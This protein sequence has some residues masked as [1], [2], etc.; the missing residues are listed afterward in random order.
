MMDVCCVMIFFAGIGLKWLMCLYVR[1]LH[2]CCA[3]LR[4]V[5]QYCFMGAKFDL[6]L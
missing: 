6:G 5:V 3:V 1:L 2:L 4:C